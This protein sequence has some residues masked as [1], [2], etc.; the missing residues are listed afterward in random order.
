MALHRPLAFALSA[1]FVLLAAPAARADAPPVA[2]L[3][4]RLATLAANR[5]AAVP[6]GTL[7]SL[8]YMVDT[9]E[10]IENRFATQSE[11][12]RRRAAG[13]LDRAEAGHDPYPEQRGKIVSLSLIHI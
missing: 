4:S 1:A 12:W 3:R 5:P 7:T 11:S 2:A 6:E 13:F 10:R 9:A 8:G